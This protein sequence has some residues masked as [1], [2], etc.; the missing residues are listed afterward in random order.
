MNQPSLLQV[1]HIFW[2][3]GITGTILSCLT[4]QRNIFVRNATLENILTAIEKY[5]PDHA[6]F[7]PALV[8]QMLSYPDFKKYDL[9]SLKLIAIGGSAFPKA[10]A[11]R[12]QVNVVVIFNERSINMQIIMFYIN[13]RVNGLLK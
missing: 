13:I 8:T 6:L 7:P 10:A 9:S 1:T 3:T 2:I 5:K 11:D 12:L 4:G